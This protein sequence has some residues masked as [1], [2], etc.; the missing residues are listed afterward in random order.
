M[1]IEKDVKAL[2]NRIVELEEGTEAVKQAKNTKLVK[3]KK[4][5]SNEVKTE[6]EAT[7]LDLNY[8]VKVSNS[9]SPLLQIVQ[10]KAAQA[11]SNDL[12]LPPLSPSPSPV[13]RDSVQL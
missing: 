4:H 12:Q 5:L 13:S 1:K 8:N 6:I 10:E 3:A 11:S 2:K 9:F 7:E